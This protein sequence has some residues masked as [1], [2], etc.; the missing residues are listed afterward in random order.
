[1]REANTQARISLRPREVSGVQRRQAAGAYLVDGSDEARAAA[2]G[3]HDRAAHRDHEVFVG[4]LHHR[5][6]ATPPPCRRN[7][8]RKPFPPRFDKRPWI[9]C[10]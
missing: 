9:L 8:Q 5:V 6:H 4:A 7:L 3:S 2:A 10:F 1:M